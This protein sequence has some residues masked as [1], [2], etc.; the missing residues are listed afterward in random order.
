MFVLVWL[1]LIV[2]LSLVKKWWFLEHVSFER[3]AT[4]NP[5][6]NI[7]TDTKFSG[8]PVD[9]NAYPERF[10]PRVDLD[11]VLCFFRA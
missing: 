1:R 3:Q 11:W 4:Y 9:A 7:D 10:C 6:F 8:G 2:G 5:L